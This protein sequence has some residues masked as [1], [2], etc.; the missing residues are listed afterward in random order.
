MFNK[1][2]PLIENI[3]RV[4]EP[5]IEDMGFELVRISLIGTGKPILEILVDTKDVET[6]ISL[7]ECGDIS[8]AVSTIMDVEN[9]MGDKAYMLDVG[10]PG[11]D[12][13][14]TKIQD[15]ERFAGK[16]AKIETNTLI[17]G[18]KR[19]KGEIMGL[20]ENNVLLKDEEEVINIPV[21]AIE[22]AKLYTDEDLLQ[23][24][25]KGK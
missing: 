4:I 13:P 7:D 21:D 5:V 10:S 11:I 25:L 22:K 8:K 15:F 6:H 9:V 16:I 3:E 23:R 18:K 1:K 20:N 14:L 2:T 12:R 24:K 19:F 17:D